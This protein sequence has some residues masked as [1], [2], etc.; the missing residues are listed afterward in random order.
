MPEVNMAE[1]TKETTLEEDF[2]RM[3]ELLA[4]MEREDI[5]I[6]DA[7]AKYEEGIKLVK[8]CN[9]KIDK[10]EKKVKT[11]SDDLKTEDFEE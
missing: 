10:V 5:G 2:A 3:E 1:K 11:L 4:E 6:E 7:F 9:D 8:S